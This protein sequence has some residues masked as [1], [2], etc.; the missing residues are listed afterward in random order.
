MSDFGRLHGSEAP[1][2]QA[3]S[4]P[5]AHRGPRLGTAAPAA[6][7]CR[8]T[9]DDDDLRPMWPLLAVTGKCDRHVRAGELDG[10]APNLAVK[11]PHQTP[12]AAA[13]SGQRACRRYAAAA[14]SRRGSFF[15]NP[16]PRLHA[17]QSSPRTNSVVWS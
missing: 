12:R 10:A 6:R 2:A 5:A 16:M 15:S 9:C 8:S 11:W 14:R 13:V 1:E 7:L 3:R 4:P 17:R